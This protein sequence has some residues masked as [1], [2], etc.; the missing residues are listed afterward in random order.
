MVTVCFLTTPA[1]IAQFTISARKPVGIIRISDRAQDSVHFRRNN[2]F[3]LYLRSQ[4]VLCDTDIFNSSHV[5]GRSVILHQKNFTEDT[6]GNFFWFYGSDIKPHGRK[7]CSE[8]FPVN[9]L[10]Q[11]LF[12]NLRNFILTADIPCF[13]NHQPGMWLECPSEPLLWPAKA[14]K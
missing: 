10:V 11:H 6:E 14:H 4:L 3:I 2:I 5:I 12:K 7:Y 9:P 8:P 1:G 13:E